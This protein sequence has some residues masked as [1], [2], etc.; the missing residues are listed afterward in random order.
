MPACV[1]YRCS[2]QQ[3]MYLY[4]RAGLAPETLPEPLLVRTG[5]LTEVMRIELSPQRRL[6]RVDVNRVIEQLA[7]PGFYLQMPPNGQI[8]VQLNEGE[9]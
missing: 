7:G 2:K 3:E 1:V 9:Y 6:A 4:L 8:Q 5:R